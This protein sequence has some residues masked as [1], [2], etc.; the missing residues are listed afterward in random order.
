MKEKLKHSTY[1]VN[2]EKKIDPKIILVDGHVYK[3]N[4]MYITRKEV[5]NNG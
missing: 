2:P 1:S 4:T 5:L 3:D